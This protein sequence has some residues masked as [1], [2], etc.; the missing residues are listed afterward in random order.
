MKCYDFKIGDLLVSEYDTVALVH[1]ISRNLNGNN[2]IY[3]MQTKKSY[4]VDY[5]PYAVVDVKLSEDI[6][7]GIYTYY[8]V[9]E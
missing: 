2:A 9:I 8:P 7:A 3:L 4:T 1:F 5:I 6:D